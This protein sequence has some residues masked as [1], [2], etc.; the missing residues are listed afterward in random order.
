MTLL[1][2][3]QILRASLE[4][5]KG[6]DEAAKKWS[7]KNISIAQ[8]QEELA[9]LDSPDHKRDRFY[10]NHGPVWAKALL[11]M[12][13]SD[14]EGWYSAKEREFII[15]AAEELERMPK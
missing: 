3:I 11:V 7:K 9:P 1:E 6:L 12:I 10:R 2:A 15:A 4:E 13:G 14:E 5:G 8:V